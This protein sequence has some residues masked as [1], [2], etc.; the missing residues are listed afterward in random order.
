[1]TENLKIFTD[2]LKEGEEELIKLTLPGAFL[3][4]EEEDLLTLNP[5]V[6]QGKAYCVDPILMISLQVS[7]QV[8]IPC[9]I[10]N[11]LT[12]VNLDHSDISFSIP[13]ED[14]SSTIFDYSEMLREE[15][16]MMIPQFVECSSGNCPHRAVLNQY[17]KK[18]L[19]PPDN[20]PFAEL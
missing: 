12:P 14:I 4:I 8:S 1:M 5:I 9:S 16:V 15:L 2:R 17:V 20:F 13:L 3:G 18:D 10:C 7:T 19:P 11:Q 6:I